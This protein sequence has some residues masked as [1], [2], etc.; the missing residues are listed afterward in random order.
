[1][2]PYPR[3]QLFESKK[4]ITIYAGA[5]EQLRVPLEYLHV[6]GKY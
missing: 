4:R 6:N 1:M 5:G 3:R 2:R